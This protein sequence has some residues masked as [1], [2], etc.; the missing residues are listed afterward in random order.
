MKT[1]SDE[2][3]A[4]AKEYGIDPDEL[5]QAKMQEH[6][7]ALSDRYRKLATEVV[8]RLPAQWDS[9]AVWEMREETQAGEIDGAMDHLY[10]GS[11]RVTEEE[12]EDDLIQSWEVVLSPSGL[13]ACSDKA[14]RWVIAHELGHVASALPTD[15]A[16]RQD[17]L[18]ED[19]A[20]QIAT[21]WGFEQE[22]EAYDAETRQE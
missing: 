18:C 19:R 17:D 2:L 16:L 15:P 3:T 22:K 11:R 5:I 13:K 12:S 14:V 20:N 4:L 10:A 21:W 9:H 7:S 8:L 6:L 1:V